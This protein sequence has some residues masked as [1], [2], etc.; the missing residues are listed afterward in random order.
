[1]FGSV[2]IDLCNNRV[3]HVNGD[4]PTVY[5]VHLVKLLAVLLVSTLIHCK[6][7]VISSRVGQ[8]CKV[9]VKAH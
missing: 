4:V 8:I 2:G 9:R 5:N 1:M 3:Q 6:K 7:Y